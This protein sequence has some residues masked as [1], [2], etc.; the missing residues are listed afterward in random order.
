MA[1]AEQ[2]YEHAAAE[3]LQ[4]VAR[5]LN[6]LN[7]ENKSV[8]KRALEGI[9]REVVERGLPGGV[10]QLLL[11]SLL[12]PVLRSLLDPMERCRELATEVLRHF[13]RSAHR[14][15]EAL[16]YLLP[17]LAQ[18]LGGPEIVE[19]AEE[20]R[21]ALL[22]LVTLTV[23]VCGKKLSPY[24]DDMV[25]IL[26]RGIVDPFPDVKKESCRCASSYAECIPEHFHMQSES[27]IKP[28]MQTI[29][30]QHSRVRV[31][32]I[33]ATGTVIQCGSGKS[34]DDVISHLAQR[35][36]DDAPQASG[37]QLLEQS[38][39][40]VAAGERRGSEGQARLF[41]LSC[42]SLPSRRVLGT[43]AIK[44]PPPIGHST[45]SK[46]ANLMKGPLYLAIPVILHQGGLYLRQAG[47]LWHI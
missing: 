29:S 47:G 15:E 25:R 21:L 6:C 26:Q 9:R 14:P 24:L 44:L 43:S 41:G 22:E 1:A 32:V 5:H 4:A 19:P 7:D 33:M 40:S 39:T 2:G 30:H 31:A 28:L 17:A 11:S 20:L 13:I 46:S 18:R 35:L 34:V 37:A 10:L 38:R 42:S 8:R 45:K 23:E 16:P 3:V 36:F 12:K 27:L